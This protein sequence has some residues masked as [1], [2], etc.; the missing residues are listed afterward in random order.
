MVGRREKSH[1]LAAGA[2]PL[3][4]TLF[5]HVGMPKTGSTSIQSMLADWALPLERRGIHVPVS[6]RAFAPG[7][8]LLYRESRGRLSPVADVWDDLLHELTTCAAPRF[9]IS[10]E[11]FTAALFTPS[12]AVADCAAAIAALGESAGVDVQIVGYVRPQ[13]QYV[14]SA[15]VQHVKSGRETKPF[16]AVLEKYADARRLDYNRIFAPWRTA[17]GQRVRVRPVQREQMPQG[18]LADFLG[19]IGATDLAGAAARRPRRNRRLGVK[20][21]QALRLVATALRAAGDAEPERLKLQL[22][23]VRWEVPALLDGDV[24]FAG[25]DQRQIDA[26]TDRFAEANARLA[27]DYA[28]SSEGILFRDRADALIRP[29][30][31]ELSAA[32]LE[33]LQR[34][35]RD[36]VGVELPIAPAPGGWSSGGLRQPLARFVPRVESKPAGQRAGAR[37]GTLCSQAKHFLR[38][39]LGSR[40]LPAYLRR[41]RWELEVPCRGLLRKMLG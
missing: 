16:E 37:I 18:L 9:A 2:S 20:H 1:R 6:G 31:T 36:K 5:V 15:Y 39:F 23:R 4:R 11:G 26:L 14:E 13:Y 35:V 40:D 22:G 27:R 17:F 29:A 10:W 25:L 7:Q 32:E 3:K 21:L 41:L 28:I 8:V 30:S 24:P 34:L 38:D 12:R 19:V 33:R